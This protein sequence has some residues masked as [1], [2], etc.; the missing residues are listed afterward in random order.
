MKIH[1]F[2]SWKAAGAALLAAGVL[3]APADPASQMTGPGKNYTG[4][5]ICIDTNEQV[6]RV[7]MSPVSAKQFAYGTNCEITLLY[8]MLK[9]TTG[10]PA[11]LRPGEKVTVSYRDCHGVNIPDRIEQQ[12]MQLAGTIKEINL[13]KHTLMLRQ[14]NADKRFGIAADCIT[15]LSDN[16]AGTLADIHSGDQVAVIYEIPDDRPTAWQITK[17]NPVSPAH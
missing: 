16:H 10:T 5:V 2:A 6:F 11:D 9:N 14:G 1:A 17:A 4:T 15:L 8:A 3:R 12:P 7:K 13:A